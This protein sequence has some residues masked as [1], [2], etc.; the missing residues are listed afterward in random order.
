[1]EKSAASCSLAALFSW[2]VSGQT[3][4]TPLIFVFL[5]LNSPSVS[6][7][8]AHLLAFRKRWEG[9]VHVSELRKEGRIANVADVVT[10]GQKVLVKVLSVTGTKASLSMKASP[11]ISMMKTESSHY[12]FLFLEPENTNP[13][14][15]IDKIINQK[16]MSAYRAV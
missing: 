10:K 3:F 16:L 9:L 12:F 5:R 7:S 13:I 1:M 6:G 2:K 14:N 15:L 4:N 8:S 11:L